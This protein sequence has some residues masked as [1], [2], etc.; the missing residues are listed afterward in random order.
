MQLG[1]SFTVLLAS[2]I[3]ALS[4]ADSVEAAP[5]RRNAGMITLPLKR[6]HNSRDDIHP[7]VVSI[8]HRSDYQQRNLTTDP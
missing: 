1:I 6:L 8:L 2:L 3:L 5:F 4:S 7:Q